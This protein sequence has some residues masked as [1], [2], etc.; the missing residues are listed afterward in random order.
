M[1]GKLQKLTQ[2]AYSD[3]LLPSRIAEFRRLLETALKEGYE[4]HSVDSMRLLQQKGLKQKKYLVLRH[5][6]DTDLETARV[7][8]EVEKD[9]GVR[10][11][12]YFR[13]STLD[14]GLMKQIDQSGGEASYHYEEIAGY[15]KLHRIY[16]PD[17]AL[18]HL[19]EIE[20]LFS[21][22][23]QFLR[24]KTGLPMKTV[25]SHGDWV[26]RK[27]KLPNWRILENQKLRHA[28]GIELEVYDTGFNQPV[29]SRHSDTLY[30]RFWKGKP[31]LEAIANHEP[32][33]YILVHPRHWKADP[34]GNLKDNA[35]RVR[36]E[37]AFRTLR[38]GQS[39]PQKDVR[40]L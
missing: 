17:I 40:G 23:L 3:F 16:S 14:V 1:A 9:L 32:F 6:I 39:Y 29:T 28:L 24:Q 27:L 2:R 38:L 26:N 25:A 12:H 36:E 22:N 20:Q 7:M 4:I 19:P 31:P 13:L 5:D 33:I 30:P 21:Q 35:R 10:A 34:W 37:L 18:K 11:S 8:W 15:C